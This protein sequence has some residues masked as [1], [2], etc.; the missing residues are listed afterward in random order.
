MNAADPPFVWLLALVVTVSL[1]MLAMLAFY[2][3]GMQYLSKME[4]GG[5]DWRLLDGL[6]GNWSFMA[7]LV[8]VAVAATTCVLL[9]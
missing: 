3:A 2:M 8:F 9:P 1:L 4:A 5:H 6:S 7:A